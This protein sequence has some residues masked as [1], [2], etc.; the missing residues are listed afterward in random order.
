MSQK[1]EITR[2]HAINWWGYCDSLDLG[3]NVLLAGVTGSGKSTLMDLIQL[4]LVGDQRS[5][6]N[7][8]ATGKASERDLK[9][10]CLGDLNQDREGQR[11][12]MREKGGP[13]YAALEFTWP[14]SKRIETWGLRIE[15]Q[16]SAQTTRPKIDPFFVPRSLVRT[17]FLDNDPVEKRK[18][19]DWPR[20]EQL[21]ETAWEGEVF[22]GLE[23]YRYNMGLPAHLNFDRDTLDHLLPSALSFT[24]LKD[25]NQF[26]RDFILSKREL[27][28]DDVRTSY[29]AYL[30][31]ERELALLAQQQNF[32]VRICDLARESE[33][34]RKD[35]QLYLYV[36]AELDLLKA[37]ADVAAAE[38]KHGEAQALLSTEQ[39]RLAQID[40]LLPTKREAEKQCIAAVAERGGA[41]YRSLQGEVRA[42]VPQIARLK[43]I[44]TTVE[45]A[46]H[47]RAQQSRRWIEGLNS[48]A[49]KLP[50]SDLSMLNAALVTL[51]R[52][53]I[54]KL[55]PA[56]RALA[57]KIASAGTN[58]TSLAQ[59]LAQAA[60]QTKK[61]LDDVKTRLAEL[62]SGRP[63]ELPHKL[64]DELNRRLP[65]D[66]RNPAACALWELCEVRDETWRPA[67]EILLHGRRGA[68]FVDEGY[69]ADAEKIFAE[70]KGEIRDESLVQPGRLRR[71]GRLAKAGSLAEKI[72]AQ[73]PG[74]RKLLDH[75]LGDIFCVNDRPALAETEHEHAVTPDGFGYRSV[76]AERPRAYSGLPTIGR[77][78]LDRQRTHW[79][80]KELELKSQF[81]RED[82]PVGRIREALER[83]ETNHLKR[84]SLHD[85]LAE[86]TRLSDL[87][88]QRDEKIAILNK[89]DPQNFSGAL[90]ELQSLTEEI[91]QLDEERTGL[92]SSEARANASG[93]QRTLENANEARADAQTSFDNRRFNSDFDFSP[94]SERIAVIHRELENAHLSVPPRITASQTRAQ[95]AERDAAAKWRDCVGERK[96][97]Q[98]HRDFGTRYEEFAVE[99]LDNRPWEERLDKILPAAVEDYSEKAKVE[100][101]TWEGLFRT[102]VLDKMR[103][104]IERLNREVDLLRHEL[105]QPIGGLRY[106]I[107]CETN[108]DFKVFHRLLELAALAHEGEL[109]GSLADPALKAE[110]DTFFGL[111]VEKPDSPEM[112][113]R[114]DYRNYFVYDMLVVDERDPDSA[115]SS[116]NRHSGR[117]SGGENQ[118]PYF[119]AILAS[120][121]RAYRR[122][123]RRKEPSL[124]VVPIDEAFSKLSNDRIRDCMVA[125][126]TLDLQ[127]IFSMSTGNIPAAFDHCDRLIT[128]SRQRTGSGAGKTRFRNVATSV[129]R[130]SAEA[131]SLIRA[132]QR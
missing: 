44:G 19:L 8:S 87:E 59:P 27:A 89:I 29:R 2:V 17:D 91:K 94:H 104:A 114:L 35:Q 116:L 21:V 12:Y 99:S 57:E 115:P 98:Q 60:T 124:A 28:V 113:R 74:A 106:K 33:S 126:R 82:A 79:R 110:L 121:L 97:L 63:P 69:Y 58:L 26:C 52:C 76:F 105:H 72:D 119:I 88:R 18:P 64:L 109:F 13:T 118:V 55:A 61:A 92:L 85:D 3:G 36:S 83:I 34:L 93:A 38:K 75:L 39:T 6:Y 131:Q 45:E 107:T 56:T 95:E 53:E 77:S 31:Y 24:F 49:V 90:K 7:T 47:A 102:Q 68:I 103:S 65:G 37:I 84:E 100:R 96:L 86:A 132:H 16:S 25:F 50:T 41:T 15:Y 5:Q 120:Y 129:V 22:N 127:G 128:V 40:L 10:Y 66:G 62:N 67:L 111:L 9:S 14:D 51:E 73:H 78:A 48:L 123:D 71:F 108:P 122:H 112:S 42:L 101:R 54:G 43:S 130:Q 125:M 46:R 11:Q 117:F 30:S 80:N 20:F 1:I 4:V 70:L 32:L 23:S 81:D